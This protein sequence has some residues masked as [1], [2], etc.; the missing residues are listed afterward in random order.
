LKNSKPLSDISGISFRA[1][2]EIFHTSDQELL[3]N[4]DELPM[5]AYHFVED[6]IRKYHFTMMAGSK[7]IY[8]ILEGSRGCPHK[9]RFCSQWKHWRGTWRTKSPR[10]IADEMEFCHANY[11]AEFIWMT[12]DYF[13]LGPMAERLCDEL[14][15]RGISEEIMWFVQARSDDIVRHRKLLAKM[16]SAGNMWI[17]TG[18]ESGSEATLARL[19]K[20]ITP[21]QT[22][23]AVRLMK[24]NDIFAQATFIIGHR[25]ETHRTLADL[26][27]FVNEIDPDLAIFMLLTPFPRTEVYEEAKKNGWIED[28]NWANYDMVHPIMPTETLSREELQEE[29][30]KCYSDFYGSWARR[31][32]GFFSSN[33]LKRRTYRYLAGQSLSRQ[34][35][36]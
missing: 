11:G 21:D 34:L 6:H 14:A 28:W 10:R 17:L 27:G 3:P 4:L 18:A 24:K 23:D 9:C 22:R 1:N 7:A 32:Q 2:S 15:K 26:R 31:L 8:T 20:N 35:K 33:K 25:K 12:D 13:P 29:L 30:L 19:G 36:P 16:R 5:P